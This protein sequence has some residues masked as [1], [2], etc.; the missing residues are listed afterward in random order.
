MMR[1]ITKTV[2]TA[3]NKLDTLM[4]AGASV[5]GFSKLGTTPGGGIMA[6]IWHKSMPGGRAAA[7]LTK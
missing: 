5:V 2:A 4:M 6:E 7:I 1:P 3:V